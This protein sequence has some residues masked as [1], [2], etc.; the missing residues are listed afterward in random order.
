MMRGKRLAQPMI[1]VMEERA[2]DA[3]GTCSTE[4]RAHTEAAEDREHSE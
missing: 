1:P 2:N 4:K 3:F